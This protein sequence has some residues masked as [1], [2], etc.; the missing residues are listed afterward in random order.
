MV[1]ALRSGW[2]E[3]RAERVIPQGLEGITTGSRF[4]ES[5]TVVIGRMSPKGLT[6]RSDQN[7]VNP[8]AGES[9]E[10]GIPDA[11]HTLGPGNV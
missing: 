7:G 2:P 8:L 10:V 4:K 5:F 1:L 9:V 11:F 3:S 6:N